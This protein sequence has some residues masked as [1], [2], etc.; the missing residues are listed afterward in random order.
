MSDPAST[1]LEFSIPE[2]DS[3]VYWNSG[4]RVPASFPLSS[5][6]NTEHCSIPGGILYRVLLGDSGHGTEALMFTTHSPLTRLRP[7]SRQLAIGNIISERPV[8][9]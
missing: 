1:V 9:L 6:H 3:R 7:R 8:H 2:S 5:R 4:P